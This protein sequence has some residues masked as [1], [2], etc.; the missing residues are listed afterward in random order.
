MARRIR[1]LIVDDSVVIRR[2][3]VHS[4]DAHD[5]M[6]VVGTASNGRIALER[7][8]IDRPD[9][10][11]LDVQMPEMDGLE[12]L[13]QLRLRGSSIPVV[14][15]SSLT[16]P[17]MQT[18]FDALEL[19]A[20]DF[21]AKPIAKSPTNIIAH[22]L[23]PR[24]RALTTR[25]SR[26][27]TP[28]LPKEITR[29]RPKT[30][31]PASLVVV[32]ASTGGPDALQR[33]FS[34]LPSDFTA[35]ILVVVHMPAEFTPIFAE[36]LR[37]T[38][39]LAAKEADDGELLRAGCVY[40]APGNRHLEIGRRGSGF[41]AIL[42]DG[43]PEN[44][45]RPAVDVLFRSAAQIAGAESLGVVLTG[46]GRDGLAGARALRRAGAA[47]LVQDEASSVVWGMPGFVARQGLATSVRPVLEIA[48][49]LSRRTRPPRLVAMGAEK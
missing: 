16:R 7:I 33:L 27:P 22:D 8:G 23:I 20:S 41:C 5:D 1:V 4:I 24:L 21:V 34:A 49:E 42:D 11:V 18:T 40:I 2:V 38:T 30:A 37:D 31:G 15:F 14:M 35:P 36:R 45:C 46:M 13:R 28:V 9:I 48:T 39:A 25:A 29:A 26:R 19:G 47:V 3:L 6:E 12:T 32:G 44:S 17:E 10:I 43:P